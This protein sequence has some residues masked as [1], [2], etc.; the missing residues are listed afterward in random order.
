MTKELYDYRVHETICFSA[1]DQGLMGATEYRTSFARLRILTCS[2]YRLMH[3]KTVAYIH[4]RI[5]KWYTN[6]GCVRNLKY[7]KTFAFW[8]L[9]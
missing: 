4:I 2:F 3:N 8:S 6:K 9:E 7:T 5:G 1:T